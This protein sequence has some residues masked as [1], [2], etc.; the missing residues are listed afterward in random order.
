MG[1]YILGSGFSVA[2]GAPLSRDINQELFVENNLNNSYLGTW[3]KKNLYNNQEKWY[4]KSSSEET[5]SRLDL[6]LHY[7]KPTEINERNIVQDIKNQLLESFIDLLS[8]QKLNQKQHLYNKFVQ[9]LSTDDIIITFNYDLLIEKTLQNLKLPQAYLGLNKAEQDAGS[10]ALFKL[11]GSINWSFCSRCK[12]ISINTLN[13]MGLSE[14]AC[15]GSCQSKPLI[16]TP[17]LYKSYSIQE[18]RIL[19]KKAFKA[20][21]TTKRIYFIGYSIPRA[22]SLVYQFLDLAYDNNLLNPEVLLINGQTSNYSRHLSIYP[23]LINTNLTFEEWIM[24][25]Q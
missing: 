2:A 22:D 12:Q 10:L 16:L 24:A 6:Y 23:S 19:W 18:F 8:R 15:S 4:I 1:V 7:L 3:I 20:L 21:L 14:E 17:T 13:K 25:Q 11:H 5:F 9:N